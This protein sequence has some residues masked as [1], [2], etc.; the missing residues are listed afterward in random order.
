[1]FQVVIRL[2]IFVREPAIIIEP[3]AVVLVGYLAHW[4]ESTAVNQYFWAIW[5]A[6]E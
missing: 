3:G 6:R 2:E 5:Q 4:L 1:M